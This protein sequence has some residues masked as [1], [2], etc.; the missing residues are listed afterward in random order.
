MRQP[1]PSGLHAVIGLFLALAG[2]RPGEPAREP[3][4]EAAAPAD[5]SIAS[6]VSTDTTSADSIA[7]AGPPSAPA[8]P[9]QVTAVVRSLTDGDS[10]CYVVLEGED[11]GSFDR[12]GPFELCERQELTGRRVRVTLGPGEVMADSC[13]GNPECTESK[14]VE[15]VKALEEMP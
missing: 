13:G 15:V 2:C 12:L 6:A 4:T 10:G 7:A 8:G 5:T 3:A 9:R 14:T 11:G 1:A